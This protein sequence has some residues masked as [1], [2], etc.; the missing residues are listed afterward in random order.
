MSVDYRSRVQFSHGRISVYRSREPV[1]V[2]EG[3]PALRMKLLS[4][5]WVWHDDGDACTSLPRRRPDAKRV[6]PPSL[7]EPVFALGEKR[8]RRGQP[9]K[10]R[11]RP[12]AI[13]GINILLRDYRR[14][15]SHAD[16]PR[17][18]IRRKRL[19][20]HADSCRF[21]SPRLNGIRH[22]ITDCLSS[23]VLSGKSG[24]P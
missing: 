4:S 17:S 24:Y 11:T 1:R 14:G 22:R 20:R 2:Y 9:L 15:V 10:S 16:D 23:F 6:D 8:K 7:N 19:A 5:S 12:A 3:P 13:A 18:G 21:R